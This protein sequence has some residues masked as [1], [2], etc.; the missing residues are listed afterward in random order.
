MVRPPTVAVAIS[1]TGLSRTVTVEFLLM[2]FTFDHSGT[3]PGRAAQGA[4]APRSAC[5]ERTTYVTKK[6][7]PEAT[8]TALGYTRTVRSKPDVDN[9][10]LA[11]A[12]TRS[13]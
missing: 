8:R 5:C 12:A 13:G 6:R 9:L 3:C 4:H 2:Q 11:P 10:T 7:T 1:S